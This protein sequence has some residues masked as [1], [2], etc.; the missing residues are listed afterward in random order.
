[1]TSETIAGFHYDDCPGH[2]VWR[3]P[4]EWLHGERAGQFPLHLIANQPSSRLHSQLDVGRTSQA[5][6]VSGREPIRI[7]PVDADSRG[8]NDGDIVRVFNDRGACYAGAIVT[9]EVR[10]Q[11]V[12]LSTGAWFDPVDPAD[13]LTACAHGNPN[14]LTADVGAS[15]LSQGCTGQHVLV[16]IERVAAAPPPVRAHQ[17]PPFTSDPRRQH[18]PEPGG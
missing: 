2:P 1:L 12:N 9:D 15:R 16:D 5:S 18:P 4:R 17:P 11:V 10:P 8:I 7:N 3:E 14:V 13:P 6:K